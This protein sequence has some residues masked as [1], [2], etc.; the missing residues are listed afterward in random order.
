MVK[1]Q[2]DVQSLSFP[3]NM[4]D[5]RIFD[6]VFRMYYAPLCD[7]SER[8]LH[9]KDDAEETIGKLFVNLWNNK[10]V[11]S[12]PDQTRAYLYRSAY[13]GSLNTIRSNK[14]RFKREHAYGMDTAFTEE[15][16]LNNM[17][18]SEMIGMIYREIDKL[19][20]HYANV[21]RMSYVEGLK[22]E[23][24]AALSGLSIQTVKNYKNKGMNMLK[25][26]VSGKVFAIISSFLLLDQLK[27]GLF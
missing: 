21:I 4:G 24:I 13:N 25:S 6:Q 15:S 18:R 27:N 23:E 14:R 16:F 26:R 2:D 8:Y 10:E 1:N 17:L 11:F 19:P 3:L 22:N 7:F 20:E 9:S 5:E 12:N